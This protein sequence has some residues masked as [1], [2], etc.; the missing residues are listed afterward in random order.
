MLWHFMKRNLFQN[1]GYTKLFVFLLFV[2]L[3]VG[4][5]GK[6]EVWSGIAGLVFVVIFFTLRNE[7]SINVYGLPFVIFVLI[8]A[9]WSETPDLTLKWGLYFGIAIFMSSLSKSHFPGAIKPAIF[10]ASISIVIHYMKGGSHY[11]TTLGRAEGTFF[12]PNAAAGFLLPAGV[13]SIYPKLD[14]PLL[15]FS[16]TG[17]I[18]TGS[19]MGICIFFLSGVVTSFFRL[20]KRIKIRNFLLLIFSLSGVFFL[21]LYF[22]PIGKRLSVE[23]FYSSFNTRTSLW[24]DTITAI[25]GKPLTGY[26]YGSF[27]RIFPYFQRSGIYSRF[28]HSF[29]LEVL[30]SSGVIGFLLFAFYFFKSFEPSERWRFSFL[31]LFLHSL[32]DFSLSA[33]ANMGIFLT[34]TGGKEYRKIRFMKPALYSLLLFLFLMRLSDIFFSV[35]KSQKNLESSIIWGRMGY[36]ISPFSA[37]KAIM[38]SNLYVEEYRRSGERKWIEKAKMLAERAITLEE[39]NYIHYLNLGSV[40]LY[41]NERKS[42]LMSFKRSIDIYPQCPRL[43]VYAG[44]LALGEGMELEAM[45]IIER[46]ISLEKILLSANNNEVVDIIELYRLKVLLLRKLGRNKEVEKVI[47]NALSLGEIINSKG[48]MERRTARGRSVREAIEEIKKM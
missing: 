3:P 18:L 28:P 14:F 43:Y 30:F 9:L 2:L 5:G 20:R 11:L 4:F 37:Q 24:K 33:P 25:S 17:L 42:A 10:V 36:A 16:L 13:L 27:E 21:I 39:K 29:I 22:S 1:P 44:E 47:N 6:E 45:R 46:G 48:L 15:L 19:R 26:G 12:H 40:Y 31:P 23:T 7:I 41:L 35:S 8:S 34:I 38:L 32:I